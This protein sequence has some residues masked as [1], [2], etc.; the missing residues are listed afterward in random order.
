MDTAVIGCGYVGH[1]VAQKLASL[2]HRV[3]AIRRSF[4]S[5]FP[6]QELGIVP[7][8]IDITD[9]AQLQRLPQTI[10]FAVNAVSSSKRGAQVYRQ[11]Y[12]EA[13]RSLID[14]LSKNSAFQHYVHISSTSVY[15]QTDGEWVEEDA[16]RTPQTETSQILVETENALLDAIKQLQFPATVLRVSGIYGPER[17]YLFQQFLQDQATM[18][19]DGARLINMIHVED[20]AAIITHLLTQAPGRVFNV[21]DCHPVTQHDFFQWLSQR[22]GKPMPPAATKEAL[23][24]RKRAITNK[25]VSNKHLL[26]ATGYQL[27]YPSFREGYE[28]EITHALAG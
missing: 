2:G 26:T 20:L 24:Q 25:K 5:S 16:A 23:K 14:H 28:A 22:L 19:G 27:I 1:R 17:G 11:V 4:P 9:P 7:L 6:A 10:A 18:V 21:T 15:G 8:E 12:L 13:T 3:Y